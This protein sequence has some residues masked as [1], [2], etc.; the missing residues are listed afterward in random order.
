MTFPFWYW[1]VLGFGLLV[2]EMLISGFF[3]LWLGLAAFATSA[4]VWLAP[5]LHWQSQVGVFAVAAAIAVTLW[6]KFRVAQAPDNQLNQRTA[7]LMGQ[8]YTLTEAISNGV[9]R[10][11]VGDGAWRVTGP[12][13][14]AGSIVRVVAVDGATLKVEPV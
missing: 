9:G 11:K 7:G 5:S 14:P 13:L 12:A 4:V 10:A 2:A 6:F 1:L 3:S 8:H